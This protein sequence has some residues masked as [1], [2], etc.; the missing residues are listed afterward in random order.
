MKAFKSSVY[1]ATTIGTSWISSAGRIEGLWPS[2]GDLLLI[3]EP[4]FTER[5]TWQS[6]LLSNRNFDFISIYRAALIIYNL[7]INF[8]ILYSSRRLYQND[9]G[10]WYIEY[11]WYFQCSFET[12]INAVL[13]HI[14]II[15]WLENNKYIF[16]R[17]TTGQKFGACKKLLLF[18]FLFF[19]F[20]KSVTHMFSIWIYFKMLFIS[21]MQSWIFS[22]FSVT[23]SFRN[24]SH[25][26]I[27][28]SR[29][30]SDYYQCWKGVLLNIFVDFVIRFPAF[31]NK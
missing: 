8:L 19:F 23:W 9:L 26:L 7:C 6:Q 25:M 12:D 4:C 11:L 3:T 21:V 2:D 24:H 31:F 15:K 27:W 29:N 20:M 16:F 18:F 22:I 1:S 5:Y 17:C 13:E 28:C 30:I 10:R 14:H